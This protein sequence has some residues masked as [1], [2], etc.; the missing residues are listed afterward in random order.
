MTIFFAFM[1]IVISGSGS[2]GRL[3]QCHNLSLSILTRVEGLLKDHFVSQVA[4]ANCHTVVLTSN[5]CLWTFGSNASGKTGHGITY[6][7]QSTPKKVEG[8]GLS[9]PSKKVVFIA[10]GA[11][12]SACITENG[13][14]YTWGYGAN[15][16][17]GH[18][19]GKNCSSPKRVKNCFL[20]GLK[21]K[22]VACGG[23]H[24][25]VCTEDGRIYSFGYGGRGQLG[26]GKKDNRFT[27][28]LIEAPLEGKFVVQVA[29]GS[30]HSMALTRKGCV[31]TWGHGANGRLGHGSEVDY[32][33]PYIVEA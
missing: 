9:S 17:L 29:C 25:L 13:S 26:H 33:T 21:A 14:T 23:S 27:P 11:W 1:T 20:V 32:T 3:G 8:G 22:E 28:T 18:S 16:R 30:E 6:G 24:T 31:Y 5:G 10:A 12:H 7:I 4:C 2:N 15:G 19:D